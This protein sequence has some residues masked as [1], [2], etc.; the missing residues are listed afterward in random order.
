VRRRRRRSRTFQIESNLDA[1][2]KRASPVG[3]ELE[4]IGIFFNTCLEVQSNNF[5]QFSI[6]N[7]K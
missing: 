4:L 7:L 6:Q 2:G 1:D 5:Y 3:I